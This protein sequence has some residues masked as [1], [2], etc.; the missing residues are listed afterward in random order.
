MRT[1]PL[2]LAYLDDDKGL[3]AAARTVS[4]LTH[5]E[6]SAGDACVLWC[7]AIRHAVL[8]GELDFTVG[9]S[10]VDPMWGPLIE[11]AIASHP[12]DFSHNGWVVEALQ[13]AVSSFTKWVDFMDTDNLRADEFRFVLERAVQGGRDTDTVAAIA[14]GLAGAVWGASAVPL[15]WQRIVHGWPGLSAID[16]VRLASEIVSGI[17]TPKRFDYPGWGK[18]DNLVQHPHDS[19]VWL[20]GV[21]VLDNLPPQVDVVISL[22][23]VGTEQVPVEGVE[24]RL[25][26]SDDPEANPNLDFVLRQTADAIET[27]RAEGKTVLVHC[28]QSISRTPTIALMYSARVLKV[29]IEQARA[30][31]LAAM[32]WAQPARMLWESVRMRGMMGHY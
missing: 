18:L 9:L 16:L 12:S 15:D 29:P 20:G 27:Y 26:D 7:L 13:G 6:A 28:V 3:I 4:E 17:P 21:G 22:C 14:G 8:T 10:H 31:V 19:G 5:F 24:V 1:A 25:I 32:P 30:D 11:T 23:R 2:A